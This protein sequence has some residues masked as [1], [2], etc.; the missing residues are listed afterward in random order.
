MRRGPP[1]DRNRDRSRLVAPRE[2]GAPDAAPLV[3]R[4]I[5]LFCFERP[6][7]R[8]RDRAARGRQQVPH[9]SPR[10]PMSAFESQTRCARASATRT[11]VLARR[12]IASRVEPLGYLA[13]TQQ[14]SRACLDPESPFGTARLGGVREPIKR[15]STGERPRGSSSSANGLPRVSATIRSRTRSSSGPGITKPAGYARPD[16][17]DL[18]RRAPVAPAAPRSAP[19]SR[20]R[21][22]PTPP[23]ADGPR[24]PAPAPTPVQP[25]RT[26]DHTQQ[27]SLPGDL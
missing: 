27:R 13:L 22:P 8:R 5:P 12:R 2:R 20:T 21:P 3:R 4:H 11:P 15:N 10:P 24:K 1:F 9:V 16:L 19:A 7:R 25:L 17:E 23:T 14:R 18:R 26:V 6:V